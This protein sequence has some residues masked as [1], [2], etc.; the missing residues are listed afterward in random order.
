M[1]PLKDN[2][3]SRHWPVVNILIIVLNILIFIFE[4]SLGGRVNSLIGTFGVTP[5]KFFNY[6]LGAQVTLLTTSIFLHG[7]WLHVLGN[8][9]YLWIF[10]DN[11]EDRM[12]HLRY[13]LF[14]ILVG[15]IATLTYIYL[16]PGSQAPLIGASGAIAGVLG[17][18]FML[19]PRAK[20]LT[21]LPIFFFIT[22][23]HIPAVV[24][25]GLWFLL[26]L[27]NETMS[28]TGPTAQAVAFAA[29]IGGF[30]SGILLVKPFQKYRY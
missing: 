7:G 5:A 21:L 22:F 4:V 9:L 27:F 6:T 28:I 11:V 23:V 25:L 24:F 26:Q 1:I 20:V 12:G 29:H 18:Y 15:Y 30:V 3:P 19:Y 2:V 8:M 14:Y 13:F 17:A 16:N 10:G